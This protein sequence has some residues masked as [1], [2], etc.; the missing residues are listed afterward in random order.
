MWELFGLVVAF[1]FALRFY[2]QLSSLLS[3]NFNLSDLYSKPIAFLAIWFVVQGIFYL[4]GRLIS[5]YTPTFFK[6]SKI[7]HYFGLIPAAIKGVVFISVILILFLIMPLNVKFKN[8]IDNSLIG[9]EL[10][11]SVAK[12]ENQIAKVFT[13]DSGTSLSASVSDEGS[14]ALNFSTTNIEISPQ[15]E[16]EMLSMT[17]A[18]REQAGLQPLAENILVRNVAREQSRDMLIRGYF[19]HNSPTG[20]GLLD[21][22]NGAHVNFSEAA[23]N[24]ALAPTTDLANI[25]LI[26]SPKHKANILDPSF[27]QVGIGVVDAGP[28][29]LMI[30]EDFIR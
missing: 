30:T 8:A 21:R 27:T 18:E 10:I 15:K 12:I 3:N 26:N 9:G 19:S 6:E 25:A 5:Y 23:E 29:G 13:N 20:Q 24:I 7:N 22:L 14:T 11:K 2:P 28:Y 16:Q 17:N 1:L 4:T